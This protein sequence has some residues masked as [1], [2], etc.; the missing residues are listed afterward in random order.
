M[1][2]R[3]FITPF[4]YIFFLSTPRKIAPVRLKA[5]KTLADARDGCDQRNFRYDRHW[6]SL[7]ASLYGLKNVFTHVGSIDTRTS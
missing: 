3:L 7:P 5:V 2:I 4:I 6:T 1:L